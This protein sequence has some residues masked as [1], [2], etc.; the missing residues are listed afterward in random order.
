MNS[1]D[2]KQISEPL[3]ATFTED[4]PTH[5]QP[6][7]TSRIRTYGLPILLPPSSNPL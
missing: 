2:D 4:D 1:Q 7:E 5:E 3:L 6:S